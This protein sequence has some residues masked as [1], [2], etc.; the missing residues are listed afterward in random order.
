MPKK[1][2]GKNLK[3]TG[4]GSRGIGHVN[5]NP[6]A[7][8]FEGKRGV[9]GSLIPASDILE[10][11]VSDEAVAQLTK[12]WD[13]GASINDKDE[14]NGYTALHWSILNS[15]TDSFVWLLKHGADPNIQDNLG[16]TPLHYAVH[17]DSA[18][19]CKALLSA[20][21]DP[22]VRNYKKQVP[23]DFLKNKNST[24][25]AL[26]KDRDALMNKHVAE[27]EAADKKMSDAKKEAKSKRV[28]KKAS[29]VGGDDTG[30]ESSEDV[31]LSNKLVK[32][33]RELY[34]KEKELKE[35][36]E[37]VSSRMAMVTLREKEMSSMKE[38][39]EELKVKLDKREAKI[40]KKERK[41]QENGLALAIPVIS[42]KKEVKM[43]KVD[44]NKLGVGGFAT[45]WKARWRG[46]LVAIKV[47]DSPE[48]DETFRKTFLQEAE[49]LAK[50][51]HGNIVQLLAVSVA[52]P[53]YCLV[54]ELCENGSLDD[55][56]KNK[57]S[58]SGSTLLRM[59]HDTARG[60]NYLHQMTPPM[61]HRDLKPQNL[62]LD[63]SYRVK[64]SDLGLVRAKG[65]TH[66]TEMS[67]NFAGSPGYMA[68]ECLRQEDYDELSDVWSYGVVLWRMYHRKN[69]PWKGKSEYEIIALVGY[70]REKLPIPATTMGD[71][72]FP[73]LL[74]KLM[75]MCWADA[76]G[77][78]PSFAKII[79][80]LEEAI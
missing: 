63:A 48:K 25:K 5:Q 21:G 66:D 47:I 17:N 73:S 31:K 77:D 6:Y 2:K 4:S 71:S 76:A 55:Y 14:D 43:K 54:M 45:V 75:G 51:R 27:V 61:I 12:L 3:R 7:K 8:R 20:G 33:E 52:F 19:L 72:D 56:L 22:S 74:F 53:N 41:L 50:L 59:A 30:S 49:F 34:V 38:K 35:R 57:K 37:S 78:R 58:V 36:E 44:L 69:R 65:A 1:A 67:G 70:N 68:P 28:E 11:A 23:L 60:M 10:A 80:M 40:R 46:D 13:Q 79:E 62:L 9:L 18:R 42:F 15:R 32:K 29:R 39:V 26:F 16:W 64:V 24:I